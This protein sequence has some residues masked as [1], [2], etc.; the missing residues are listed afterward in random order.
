MGTDGA[1]VRCLQPQLARPSRFRC[2]RAPPPLVLV[3]ASRVSSPSDTLASSTQLVLLL[4][5]QHPG[6]PRRPQML[7]PILTENMVSARPPA[8]QTPPPA[9]APP[10]PPQPPQPP[11]LQP[12]C[13]QAAPPARSRRWTAT[14]ACATPTASTSAAPSPARAARAQQRPQPPQRA[15]CPQDL[16]QASPASSP[17]PMEAPPSQAAQNGFMAGSTRASCGAAPRSTQPAPM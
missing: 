8:P 5:R 9:P 4:E 14:P 13:P 7:A 2:P 12:R 10:P 11:Q 15:Q 1:I 16:L 3:L 17:S 6:A